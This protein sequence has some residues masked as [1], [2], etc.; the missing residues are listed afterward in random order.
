VHGVGYFL[1]LAKQVGFVIVY[2][3][4]IS[5]VLAGAWV[6]AFATAKAPPNQARWR[7]LALGCLPPLA[8]PLAILVVGVVF[9]SE[10]PWVTGVEAPAYPGYL[11]DGLFYVQLPLAVVTT[12]WWRGQ[13]PAVAVSWV[14]AGYVSLA[15]GVIS[16]SSVTGVWP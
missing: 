4:P 2:F 11:I 10:P 5:L 14:C 3:W 13:R 6:W 1:A 9:S 15:A 7:V 12:R 16:A 8:F